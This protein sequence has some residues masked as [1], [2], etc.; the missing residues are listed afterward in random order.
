[1]NIS[2]L[3]QQ[4]WNS[5]KG[6]HGGPANPALISV[7]GRRARAGQTS[8]A[9]YH[10]E[11]KEGASK[12]QAWWGDGACQCVCGRRDMQMRDCQNRVT[13]DGTEE[14]EKK[15]ERNGRTDH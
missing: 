12:S 11:M 2:W 7:L 15:K 13:M 8:I 10:G 1:M 6:C 14:R 9:L 5:F 4:G 3:E